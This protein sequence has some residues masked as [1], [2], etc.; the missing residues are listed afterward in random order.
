MIYIHLDFKLYSNP[1]Y[2]IRRD[3]SKLYSVTGHDVRA[4]WGHCC[5]HRPAL[6]QFTVWLTFSI[7]APG[8][9]H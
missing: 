2:P 6:L 8:C 1:F 5:E 9:F 4:F 3:L 7:R